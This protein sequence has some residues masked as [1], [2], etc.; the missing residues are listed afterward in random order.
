MDIQSTKSI[1]YLD[2]WRGVAILLVLYSHFFVGAGGDLGVVLFFVLSGFL[3]SDLLFQRQTGIGRFFWRR[4]TRILPT[5]WLY[6][7]VMA[8][9]TAWLQPVPYVVPFDEMASTLVFLRTYFPAD[10]S[11]WS[12]SWPIGHLWSL[13]VEEHAYLV[14][15]LLAALLPVIGTR[16]LLRALMLTCVVAMCL[17]IAYY[18]RTPPAGASP[19]IL[20]TEC[21][22]LGLM[23]SAWIHASR[24]LA[25]RTLI[26][27]GHWLIT[28]LS[29]AAALL[30]YLPQAPYLAAPG[31]APLLL[32]VSVNYLDSA[33]APL[34][35][36][37]SL[38]LLRWFGL[39]SYSLYIWQQPF[40][41]AMTLYGLSRVA[42]PALALA[43]GI[44]AFYLF[45]HPVR[46]YLNR[47]WQQHLER[48]VQP[49]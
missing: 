28:P 23:A 32:A 26:R 7:G 49:A 5:Y 48:T 18:A 11:I 36:L 41:K 44:G 4:A 12:N 46:R 22:A 31:L 25:T 1:P 39:C 21:A 16:M 3:V 13:N 17:V 29:L 6:L 47:I 27:H 20:R 24:P 43:A 19:W 14:L 15:G 8:G 45:E 38:P 42:A 40:Y 34:L 30:C 10:Q 35:R 33:P 9:Y 2:G 37:L